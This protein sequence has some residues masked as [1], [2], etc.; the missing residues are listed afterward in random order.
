MDTPRGPVVIVGCSHPGIENILANF[1]TRNRIE[2][3][4]EVIGGM[5]LAVS[6]PDQ[7]D[8]TISELLS[9]YRVQRMA[10]G[11][12]TGERAFALIQR[13]LGR[14]YIYAGVGEVF[15]L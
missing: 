11:H 7:I 3:V 13:L 12:C 10:P 15:P 2:H 8:H 5:H 9:H 14:N 1:V 6:T 4:Y